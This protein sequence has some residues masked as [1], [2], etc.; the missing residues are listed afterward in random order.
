MSGRPPTRI[1]APHLLSDDDRLDDFDSREPSLD[2]WLR[3]RA[4]Q[5]QN[6]GASRTFVVCA[7]NGRVVGYYCLSTASIA[8][9]DA[10]GSLRRNM[11][12]PIPMV[13][14]GRLAVDHEWQG[15]GI[16]AGLLKDATRRTIEIA[17]EIG[18]R[19]LLVSAISQD[20]KRFYQRWGFVASPSDPMLLT[21]RLTEIGQAMRSL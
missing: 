20:A 16:G 12:D 13:L 8:H 15:M 2:E 3:S 11:P 21:A 17:S 1:S 18:V 10:P 4:R 6:S 9:F 7:T 14:L 19:G 5:N